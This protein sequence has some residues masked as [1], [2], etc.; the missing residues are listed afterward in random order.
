MSVTEYLNRARDCLDL[1]DD[2]N[3]EFRDVLLQAAGTW[4]KMAELEAAR[5]PPTPSAEPDG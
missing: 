3:G 2:L 1:A 4:L 5:Q